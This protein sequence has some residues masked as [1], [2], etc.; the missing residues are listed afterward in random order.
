[1]ARRIEIGNRWALITGG[2][3]GIGL[4]IAKELAHKRLRLI[5]VGRN[6]ERLTQAEEALRSDGA[7]DVVSISTDLATA[8][9]PEWLYNECH[10][11]GMEVGLL[12]NNAGT[13]IYKDLEGLSAERVVQILALHIGAMT[14]LSRLFVADMSKRGGGY[15]LNISS[16][17][18]STPL[19]GLGMYSATKAYINNF[20]LALAEEVCGQGIVV[21]SARPGAVATDL[22]GL[23]AKWQ[24][25]GVRLGIIERPKD[26]LAGLSEHSCVAGARWVRGY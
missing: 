1:M 21:C 6:S 16:M 18:A 26:W 12:V 23:S 14:T 3:S 2:S 7:A 11:R 24:R 4:A 20:T 8:D 13:F 9:G 17:A 5:I 19:P 25:V 22:Y 15:V 10:R